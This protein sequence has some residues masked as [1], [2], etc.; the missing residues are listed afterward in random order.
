MPPRL[1]LDISSTSEYTAHLD[2]EQCA[3]RHVYQ[4]SMTYHFDHCKAAVSSS[5]QTGQRS[6]GEQKTF[7]W[8]TI[9]HQ[10]AVLIGDMDNLDEQRLIPNPQD[11]AMLQSLVHFLK[12]R[13][14][15]MKCFACIGT[16]LACFVLAADARTARWPMQSSS[17]ARD[18]SSSRRVKCCSR[19]RQGNALAQGAC[20]VWL[21]KTE[22]RKYV[23]GCRDQRSTYAKRVGRAAPGRACATCR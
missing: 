23:Q 12:Y 20:G 17:Q 16:T 22:T 9:M 19:Q 7:E 3:P 8:T 18:A 10:H 15:R 5:S 4:A 2:K 21:V 6:F 11:T 14:T 1:V 13:D